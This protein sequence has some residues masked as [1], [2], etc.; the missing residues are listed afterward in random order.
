[1]SVIQ[2]RNE[3]Q[4]QNVVAGTRQLLGNMLV[5]FLSFV[6]KHCHVLSYKLSFIDEFLMCGL[7]AWVITVPWNWHIL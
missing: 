4:L 7:V 2:Q 5:M 1:M 3:L 6:F